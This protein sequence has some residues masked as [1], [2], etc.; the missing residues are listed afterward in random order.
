[1]KAHTEIRVVWLAGGI[2][3]R[4]FILVIFFVR[5]K[6]WSSGINHCHPVGRSRGKIRK[7]AGD[8]NAEAINGGREQ[9]A[10]CR[11]QITF[12]AAVTPSNLR[13]SVAHHVLLIGITAFFRSTYRRQWAGWVRFPPCSITFAFPSTYNSI[14]VKLK[15]FELHCSCSVCSCLSVVGVLCKNNWRKILVSL[16]AMIDGLWKWCLHS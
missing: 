8:N 13:R 5:T 12:S 6:V 15:I 16:P 4:W 7:N 11:L 2:N 3:Q 14:F 10:A 1:M 9:N